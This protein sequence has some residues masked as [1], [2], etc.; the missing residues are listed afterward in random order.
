MMSNWPE[1]KKEWNS[2]KRNKGNGEEKLHAESGVG[3]EKINV[4][5]VYIVSNK[6]LMEALEVRCNGKPLMLRDIIL[7]YGV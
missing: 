4:K 3:E 5:K 1:H 7:Q 6:A 2:P